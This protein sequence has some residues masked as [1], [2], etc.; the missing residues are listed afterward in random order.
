MRWRTMPSAV[1]G[2]VA[3]GAVTAAQAADPV[4]IGFSIS[5]TGMFAQATPT[6]M[7]AYEL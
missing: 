3:L 5:Q 1:A 7:S 2:L 4:R 6:Q